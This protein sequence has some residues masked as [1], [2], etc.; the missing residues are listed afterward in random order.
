MADIS[1]LVDYSQVKAAN[2]EINK[3]GSAAEKSARVFAAAFKMA[4]AEQKRSLDTVRQQIAFSQKLEAQRAKEAKLTLEFS[5][6][7]QA[8]KAAEAKAEQKRSLDTVRQQIAFS[9]KLEA[10]RAKEAKLTL[11]FS[12]R[13]QAQKA[14]EA[15]AEQVAIQNNTQA[16][17]R[18]R[19][20]YD[21]AYSVQQKTLQLKTM[22][23]QAIAN[24]TMTVREAGA[25]LLRYK[26]ALIASNHAQTGFGKSMNRTGVLTQQAGY[27]VGDFLVQVQSG[28]NPMVAFGQQATQ[29]V[30]ALY[31]LPPAA[32]AA[33]TSILGLSVSFGA[34]LPIIG[35]ALPLIT[36]LGAAWMRSRA[37]A[38]DFE[39]ATFDI[40]EAAKK[41]SEEIAKYREEVALLTSEFKTLGEV[42]LDLQIKDLT[43]Q[44]S[45]LQKRGEEVRKAALSGFGASGGMYTQEELEKMVADAIADQNTNLQEQ[46]RLKQQ[47]LNQLVLERESAERVRELTS[48]VNPLIE[49]GRRA[50]FEKNREHRAAL[51]EQAKLE[52]EVHQWAMTNTYEKQQQASAAMTLLQ[53]SIKVYEQE[54]AIREEIGDAAVEALKLA[55]VDLT[56]P[57]S[58]AAIEAAKLAKQMGMSFNNA[59]A[60][61]NTMSAAQ[62]NVDARIA[63]QAE[64][65]SETGTGSFVPVT[66]TRGQIQDAIDRANKEQGTSSGR[67]GGGGA[68]TKTA[69]EYLDALMKEAEYKSRLVGLSEEEARVKEIVYQA[70]QQGITVSEAQAQV[71]ASVEAATRKLTEA[72][73]QREAMI[74]SVQNNI[75][76]A[77]MSMVDGSKSVL[78]AFK[79]MLRNILLEIYKQKVVTPMAEGIMGLFMAKGGAFNNGVQMFANGGVVGS[80]TMFGHSGGLGVMGEAGPEAIMPLKRGSDGKLG[81]A[82][83]GNVTVHQTFNFAANG[84]DSVKRIIAQAA[85]QIAQMTQKQIMDSR[86]RGGQMKATFS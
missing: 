15:K 48:G 71:I 55:G 20:S 30:G 26:Q 40:N 41:S 42:G 24:E 57:I 66:L 69:E 68:T 76:S 37:S 80:P 45:D 6:R 85:P 7:M 2:Q 74:N 5:R 18:F 61:V 52:Q 77:F 70:Q 3:V 8:Q 73:K 39:N 29:L 86:R 72:E 58:S 13:M 43:S 17:N 62:A 32:L 81:V 54:K 36:A 11:D 4:E 9:Q 67:S 22:L 78:D 50:Q 49:A 64:L 44:I 59:L 16:I 38:K 35:I 60:F 33:R 28:T 79:D 23:R 25:E 56:S 10:Q 21:Q 82:G 63:A 27:Q 34:M 47:Q 46:I 53:N 31:Y 12:R 84:D 75:E 14:A 1:F 83:G 19:S 65:S 51:I